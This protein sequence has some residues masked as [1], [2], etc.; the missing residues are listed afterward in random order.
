MDLPP[1]AIK[2]SKAANDSMKKCEQILNLLTSH[3]SADPFKEPVDPVKLG[4]PDYLQKVKEPMD[5]AT[6]R[7]KLKS[8]EYKNSAAFDA[9]IRKI[10]HNSFNYN[11][12]H[13]LIYQ[14]TVEMSEYFDKLRREFHDG[15]TGDEIIE[16]NNK[17]RETVNK[18]KEFSQKLQSKPAL[19]KQPSVYTD[20]GL[21]TEE[22]KTLSEMIKSTI[23]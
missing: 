14:M 9:D 8:R 6:V 10:W 12:K 17:V 3:K 21:S 1:G 18:N 20:V 13:T 16:T 7:K 22:K 2:N 11:V 23:S 4:I 19:P 5:L 15:T